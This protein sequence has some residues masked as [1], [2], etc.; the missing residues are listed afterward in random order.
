MPSV[1]FDYRHIGRYPIYVRFNWQHSVSCAFFLLS[2]Y[3]SDLP[4]WRGKTFGIRSLA[5]CKS[6]PPVL[7]CQLI[8]SNIPTCYNSRP[9]RPR[10]CVDPLAKRHS[11]CSRVETNCLH[12][13]EWCDGDV[14]C[15]TVTLSSL[16]IDAAGQKPRVFQAFIVKHLWYALARCSEGLEML[17]QRK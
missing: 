3:R 4:H 1:C 9:S 17:F 8:C 15:F 10:E 11:H 13:Q 12:S 6:S 7:L 14:E 2:W 5:Q 16:G